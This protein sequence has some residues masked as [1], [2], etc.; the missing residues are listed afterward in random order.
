[1]NGSSSEFCQVKLTLSRRE[2]D[3]ATSDQVVGHAD[4]GR[5]I[6]TAAELRQHG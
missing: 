5:R 6:K 1:M 2:A 3:G 4:N